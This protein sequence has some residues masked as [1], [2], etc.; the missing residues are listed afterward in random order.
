LW[1]IQRC[2][3]PLFGRSPLFI[4]SNG[5]TKLLAMEKTMASLAIVNPF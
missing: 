3:Y 5:A 1:A 4:V 2:A